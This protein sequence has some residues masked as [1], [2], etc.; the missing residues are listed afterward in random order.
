[1]D[2]L[3]Q[4]VSVQARLRL[5]H[6]RIKEAFPGITRVAIATYDEGT[7]VLRTFVHSTDGEPPFKHYDARLHDVPSLAELARSGRD[8]VID[9]LTREWPT[10]HADIPPLGSHSRRLVDHGYRSSYTK[11]FYDR[12]RFAGFLFFDSPEPRYFTRPVVHHLA[13][14]TALIGT[15]IAKDMERARELRSAVEMAKDFGHIHD[16][17]T[18]GHLERMAHYA[19]V[20]GRTLASKDPRDGIDDEFVEYVFLFAPLHDIGKIAV[21]DKILLKNDKLTEDE[22]LIM[23]RHVPQGLD[24]VNSLA[25]HFEMHDND[26]VNILRHIVAY[27]HEAFDGS[28]YPHHLCGTAI[29]L[30][31]RIVTV[32]DVFDA[33]TSRRPYKSAW[34][35]DAAFRFLTDHAGSKFDPD[36]VAA[37]VENAGRVTQIQRDFAKLNNGFGFHE[38]YSRDL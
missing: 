1:L 4:D 3:G 27:H 9:D 28:G 20:I 14:F 24:L 34:S 35:N 38:G 32:A 36:C 11:P 37:L 16:A 30:E 5:I 18:G 17:E 15:M 13:I 22:F 2:S 7:H 25:R 12:G 6:D 19:E 8:R 29:P 23:Q 10:P 33:L 26:K 31:A 21:P